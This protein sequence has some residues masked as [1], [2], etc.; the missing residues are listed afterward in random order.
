MSDNVTATWSA[1]AD[2][3]MHTTSRALLFLLGNTTYGLSVDYVERVIEVPAVVPVPR[4]RDWLLGLA[5]YES[6]PLPLI[7]PRYFLLSPGQRSD[8]TVL[9]LAGRAIVV[10]CAHGRVLLAVDQLVTIS[11]LS[12][13]QSIE[14]DR[15]EFPDQYI[16][17]ACNADETIVGV[18]SVPCLLKAAAT[19]PTQQDQ[20]SG[21][22]H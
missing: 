2:E 4:A 5:V 15:P 14:T 22:L 11:D 1:Q 8:E 20:Q 13:R 18:V 17:F 19:H 16:E 7:D 3:L 21:A 9:S 6:T 10:S 12:G